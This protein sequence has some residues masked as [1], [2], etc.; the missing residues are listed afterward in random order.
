MANVILY[1]DINQ[2]TPD[3]KIL[4]TNIEYFY[5]ILENIFSTSKEERFFRPEFGADLDEFL[6]EFMDEIT[7]L[8]IHSYIIDAVSEWEP[9]L[10]LNYEQTKVIPIPEE[11][12]YK[13]TLVFQ[14]ANIESGQSFTLLGEIK[15]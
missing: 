6:M 4:L 10:I 12:K 7:A 13:I 1:S 11:N 2:S 14:I 3:K 8:K 9:N 15:K 5:Q